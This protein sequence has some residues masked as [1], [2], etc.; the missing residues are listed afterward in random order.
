MASYCRPTAP[1][2]ADLLPGLP[3]HGPNLA[4]PRHPQRLAATCDDLISTEPGTPTPDP[5]E[6]SG[7]PGTCTPAGRKFQ[8]K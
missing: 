7:L 4:S 8:P 6:P 5:R 2:D 1:P 3:A